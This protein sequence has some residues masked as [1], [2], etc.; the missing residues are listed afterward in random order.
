MNNF[1]IAN[2]E[3]RQEFYLRFA[4][5][6]KRLKELEMPSEIFEIRLEDGENWIYYP[7]GVRE[8]LD[9]RLPLKVKIIE[10]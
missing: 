5:L 8:S 6:E 4:K 1:D 10:K 7:D 2:S 3:M 9:Y